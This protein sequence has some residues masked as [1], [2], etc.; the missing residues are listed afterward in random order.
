[1]VY[2][3]TIKYFLSVGGIKK[4]WKAVIFYL[5]DNIKRKNLDLSKERIVSILYNKL[6]TIS[7]DN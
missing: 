7:N 3:N 1:M 4:I 2:K 5:Y 6:E